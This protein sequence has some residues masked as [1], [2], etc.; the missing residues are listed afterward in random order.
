MHAH[1]APWENSVRRKDSSVT[2]TSFRDSGLG[3]RDSGLGEEY[4]DAV[5]GHPQH[6]RILELKHCGDPGTLRSGALVAPHLQVPLPPWGACTPTG[7]GRLAAACGAAKASSGAAVVA[8]VISGA[9]F[10][11][12]GP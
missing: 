6:I 8:A 7:I 12:P 2:V 9:P 11:G 3:T 10:E 5:R 4:R 1:P